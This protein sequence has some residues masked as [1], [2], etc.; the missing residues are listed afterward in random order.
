MSGWLFL[1]VVAVALRARGLGRAAV[2]FTAP[3]I[4]VD[5]G[6]FASAALIG[7]EWSLKL[8]A[9]RALLTIPVLVWVLS[10]R[11]GVSVRS[12][13]QIWAAPATASAIMLLSMRWLEGS[14]SSG[15]LG[16]LG[17]ISAGAA[18][19]GAALVPLSWRSTR[20]RLQVGGIWR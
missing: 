14:Q 1:H 6:I 19:Y 7:L 17:L 8:W 5:V 9:V 10:V 15:A 20:S 3:T 13:A 4:L 2:Y 16:L 18:V 11:L 12:L